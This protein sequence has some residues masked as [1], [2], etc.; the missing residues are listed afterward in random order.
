MSETSEHNYIRQE[1]EVL[2]VCYIT[3]SPARHRR[4]GEE[5]RKEG[6]RKEGREKNSKEKIK[7]HNE[8]RVNNLIF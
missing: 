8:L 2:Q 3:E 6:E 5:G 4:R 1:V 7:H